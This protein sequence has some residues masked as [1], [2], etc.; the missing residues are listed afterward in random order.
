MV[1]ERVDTVFVIM[2][3]EPEYQPDY[4]DV[5]AP[6][7]Q[8]AGLECL[9]ADQDDLGYIQH[10]MF[11]RI[12]ESPVVVADVSGY[13]PNVFYELGVSHTAASKTVTVVREDWVDRIPFD[14]GPYRVIVFPRRPDE[15]A[16][17]QEQA[18]YESARNA[19]IEHLSA[20]IATVIEPDSDGV[21]NPVRSYL[22]TRS[23]VT[24][25]ESR[26]ID[27]LTEEHEREMVR[28][29]DSEIV[30]LSIANVHFVEELAEV[31]QAGERTKPLR[32]RILALDPDDLDS[33]RYVY[34][35]REGRVVDDEEF[36]ELHEDDQSIAKRVRRALDELA[37][38]PDFHADLVYYRGIPVIWAYV[39]DNSRIMVGN[40]AM[41]RLTARL[42]TSILVRDDPRTRSMYR[43]YA[44]IIEGVASTAA[45]GAGAPAEPAAEG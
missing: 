24:C 7:V 18:A 45:T 23:P 8:K 26:Y 28:A 21:A 39:V 30:A 5:I 41:N 4:D 12:F 16:N 32:V 6:A 29:A 19:A 25:S 42:P 31:I 15:G 37:E 27:S 11:E 34:H 13:N 2:P 22:A 17:E 9:R 20:A 1:D 14:I 44:E 35:L 38:A 40:Y 36:K 33:W 10:M 43:Y 3:F